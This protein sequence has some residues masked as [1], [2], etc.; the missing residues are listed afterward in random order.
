MC[1]LFTTVISNDHCN[2][3]PFVK[4]DFFPLIRTEMCYLCT[5][6]ISPQVTPK[7]VLF[8]LRWIFY[9]GKA[10]SVPWRDKDCDDDDDDDGDTNQHRYLS[11]IPLRWSFFYN[12]LRKCVPLPPW[13]FFYRS[14]PKCGLFFSPWWFLYQSPKKC[15]SFSLRWFFFTNS[16]RNDFLFDQSSFSTNHRNT[17]LFHY[18]CFCTNQHWNAVP[19]YHDGIY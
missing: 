10:L 2:E 5:M 11:P 19:F 18:G 14:P 7:C 6:E 1:Y 3:F 17:F 4:G 12:W 15:V 16:Q 9:Q 13:W 8:S